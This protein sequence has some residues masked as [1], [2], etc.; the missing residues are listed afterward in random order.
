MYAIRSYYG[1]ILSDGNILL[2]TLQGG[3]VIFDNSGRVVRYYNIEN[4]IINNNSYSSF[5][6]YTGAIWLATDN[7]ISR[8]DYQSPA[9]YFDSRNQFNTIP[10]TIIV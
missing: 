5:Q 6:D 10:Y 4:G 7:G 8:I 3:A 9:V 1:S 2:G